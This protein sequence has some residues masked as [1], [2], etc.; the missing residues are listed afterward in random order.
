M[1]SHAIAYILIGLMVAFLIDGLDAKCMKGA[2]GPWVETALFGLIW[3]VTFPII[4]IQFEFGL[5][6]PRWD[7]CFQLK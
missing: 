2:H 3:P 5:F 1:K 4:A 6:S 7:S